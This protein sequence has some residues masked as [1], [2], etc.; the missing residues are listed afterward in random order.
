M[1]PRVSSCKVGRGMASGWMGVGVISSILSTASWNWAGD[2]KE[3][4]EESSLAVVRGGWRAGCL[5][6]MVGIAPARDPGRC[7]RSRE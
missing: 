1:P 4:V 7:G 3:S 5:F 6:T 2:P